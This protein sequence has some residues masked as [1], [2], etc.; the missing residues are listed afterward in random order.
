MKTNKKEAKKKLKEKLD[1]YN[2]AGGRREPMPRPTVFR[3][4][5]KY[6][7]NRQKARDR[8]ECMA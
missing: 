6:D 3:D 8:M 5:S 2:Q 7:R 1:M 4:K